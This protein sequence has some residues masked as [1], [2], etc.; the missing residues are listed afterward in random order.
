MLIDSLLRAPQN[1]SIHGQP[2]ADNV[3]VLAVDRDLGMVCPYIFLVEGT[4]NPKTLKK[5][6]SPRG[7]RGGSL[8]HRWMNQRQ[9]SGVGSTS[10][11]KTRSE[12]LP[13]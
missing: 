2:Y 8:L 12:L 7:I 13:P 11:I 3:A 10:G 9:D 5:L 1:L 6:G 4:S